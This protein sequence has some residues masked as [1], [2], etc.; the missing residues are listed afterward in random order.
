MTNTFEVLKNMNSFSG[1]PPGPPPR[2]NRRR[3]RYLLRALRMTCQGAVSE[4]RRVSTAADKVLEL[5]FVPRPPVPGSRFSRSLINQSR[6]S[7]FPSELSL[8]YSPLIYGISRGINLRTGV[9]PTHVQLPRGGLLHPLAIPGKI[10]PLPHAPEMSPRKP[11]PPPHRRID[12][13]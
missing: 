12:K 3:L 6:F 7:L 1:P 9:H 10:V 13:P 11:T 8:F 4:G 5:L 2:G